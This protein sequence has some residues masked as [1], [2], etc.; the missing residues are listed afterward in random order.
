MLMSGGEIRGHRGCCNIW[1]SSRPQ[2]PNVV[3]K[4]NK[5]LR[6][7]GSSDCA[8]HIAATIR[9]QRIF[10]QRNQHVNGRKSRIHFSFFK[11]DEIDPYYS[12]FEQIPTQRQQFPETHK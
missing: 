12:I 10:L 1:S 9:L 11:D 4:K 7:E 2:S 5:L 3:Q 6:K 8:D